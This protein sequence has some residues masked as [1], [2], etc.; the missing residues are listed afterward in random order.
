MSIIH[1]FVDLIPATEELILKDPQKVHHL[2]D[3]LRIKRNEKI[4]L[5]DQRNQYL[6]RIKEIQ[7]KEI[8]L[9]KEKELPFLDILPH[10][11]VG[12]SLIKKT[13]VMDDLIDK[14][15]QLGV[16]KIIPLLSE[17]TQI[18]WD[19]EK[20]L[21]QILR[22]RKISINASQQAKRSFLPII[23]KVKKLEEIFNEE[24]ELKLIFTLQEKGLALNSFFK[25]KKFNSILI[26]IGPEGDFS[27]KEINLAKK[28]GFLT[29]SLGEL[30]LRVETAVISVVSFIRLLY[31]KS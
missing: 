22:W 30:T 3:V 26:L 21:K 15:T 28:K 24:A 29:A 13:K 16:Y 14:L 1:I 19:E 9:I 27:L 18:N 25:E 5:F 2:K 17:R 23:E 4:I 7:D 6:F 12:L 11:S 10:I 8:I 20:K 31:A